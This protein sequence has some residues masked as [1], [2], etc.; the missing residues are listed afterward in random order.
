MYR[1]IKLFTL[2]TFMPIVYGQQLVLTDSITLDV[3]D[4]YSFY[5]ADIFNSFYFISQKDNSLLK[6]DKNSNNKYILQN[7]DS[8]KKLFI[9]NPLFLVVL[10]KFNN[11]LDFY[12]DK[13][14]ST[15]DRISIFSNQIINPELIYVQNN[16]YLLY[17][18]ELKSESFIQY[19][20]RVQ[21]D[22]I[23]SNALPHELLENY[24][25]K[26][27]YSSKQSKFIL[28]KSK[29]FSNESNDYKIVK[30]NNK[31]VYTYDIPHLD[32]YG[33]NEQNFYWINKDFLYYYDF[34]NAPIQ[35]RLPMVGGK[36]YILNKYLFLWK[37]KVMYLYKIETE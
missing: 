6:Y 28:L 9:V 37:S 24:I 2:F 34:E 14:I 27:I 32:I 8:L 7:F 4:S 25:K 19:D 16:R 23:S 10:D 17:F 35:I 3:S 12:D 1:L 31:N 29:E 22:I 20:Y 18:D 33:W 21:K 11:I 26:D 15:Q 30:Q 5:Q 13:L 36:Y